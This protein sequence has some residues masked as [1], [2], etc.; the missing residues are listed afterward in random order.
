MGQGSLACY[1]PW[2]RKEAGVTERLS[3]SKRGEQ[4]Q[5]P[6]VSSHFSETVLGSK[7][8]PAAR[9]GAYPRKLRD[10]KMLQMGGWMDTDR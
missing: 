8:V 5:A 10:L 1:S 3:G 4:L 2:G 9:T 7:A 6:S